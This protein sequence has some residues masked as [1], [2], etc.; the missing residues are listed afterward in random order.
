MEQAL[1]G[2]NDVLAQWTRKSAAYHRGRAHWSFRAMLF[3]TRAPGDEVILTL[4]GI[5]ITTF[6]NLY[7]N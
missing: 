6:L 1:P 5:K 2:L 4:S 3:K 7:N